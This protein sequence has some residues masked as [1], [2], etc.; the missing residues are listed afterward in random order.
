MWHDQA[1][2]QP[3]KARELA[4]GQEESDAAVAAQV[5]RVET[6]AIRQTADNVAVSTDELDGLFCAEIAEV[7]GMT[8]VE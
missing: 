1:R 4:R 7:L 8:K 2:E 5:F 6:G 3:A